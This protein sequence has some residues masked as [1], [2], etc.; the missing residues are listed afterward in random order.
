MLIKDTKIIFNL[1]KH[2]GLLVNFFFHWIL[3]FEDLLAFMGLKML[4]CLQ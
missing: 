1:I 4:L 2:S 3:N